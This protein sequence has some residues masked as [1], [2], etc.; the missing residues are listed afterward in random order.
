M[1]DPPT[2]QKGSFS[3]SLDET[4]SELPNEL[5]IDFLSLSIPF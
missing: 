5:L 1:A 4:V 2:Y 3:S